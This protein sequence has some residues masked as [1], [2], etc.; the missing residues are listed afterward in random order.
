MT[1]TKKNTSQEALQSTI[2]VF[3]ILGLAVFMVGI[4]GAETS[5]LG[6]FRKGECVNLRQICTNCTYVNLTSVE[7]TGGN[8]SI[9]YMGLNMAKSGEEYN[10]T[11]CNTSEIA[12][13]RYNI[14]GDKDGELQCEDIDF[15]INA[16]GFESTDSRTSAAN[17]GVLIIF[18]IAILFFV[19]FLFT[20]KEK[21]S[22][23]EMGNLVTSGNNR[24]FKWTF[25][26][27]SILFLTIAVNT[28]FISIYN[29]IGDT[30]IG[31]IFDKLG[32][33]SYYMFWFSFG[34]LIFLWVFT[35]IASLADKRRMKQAESV[36]L[37][38]NFGGFR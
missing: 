16:G 25:F 19:A 9:W 3:L 10:Y 6:T 7:R 22:Q 15:H 29:D 24:P 31:A 23:D 32:A 4:I 14:C 21:T 5:N 18:G 20:P 8:Y 30:Q 38:V 36:G 26:L 2:K 12:D 34:L 27:L 35:T 33:F 13:Y 17:R 37:P 28:T 11:F 1:N